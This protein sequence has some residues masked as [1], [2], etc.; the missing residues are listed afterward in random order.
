MSCHILTYSHTQYA[1][2]TY[3]YGKVIA[4]LEQSNKKLEK[5]FESSISHLESVILNQSKQIKELTRQLN[6]T[7]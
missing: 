3:N 1:K 4:D 7:N 2:S 5:E 6:K